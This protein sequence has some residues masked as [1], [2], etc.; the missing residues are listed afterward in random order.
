MQG[1]A[2]IMFFS[3]ALPIRGSEVRIITLWHVK[4]G[5][6]H[7]ENLSRPRSSLLPRPLSLPSPIF[8]KIFFL[9]PPSSVFTHVTHKPRD[10][11]QRKGG[12]GIMVKPSVAFARPGLCS[13]SAVCYNWNAL[14]GNAD[15]E[16][17][18]WVIF[19]ELYFGLKREKN[20]AF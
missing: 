4:M 11:L 12:I 13:G 16:V 19:R 20:S 2:E 6:L 10:G 8:S 9:S 17:D 1:W 14:F 7:K 15:T 3:R 5:R 18:K